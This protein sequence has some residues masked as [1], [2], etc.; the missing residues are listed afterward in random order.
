MKEPFQACMLCVWRGKGT[1][2]F[3]SGKGALWGNSSILR[4]P[5][6]QRGIEAVTF[7]ATIKYRACPFIQTQRL[8]SQN[9]CVYEKNNQVMEMNISVLNKVF[10]VWFSG[11]VDAILPG[12]THPRHVHESTGP[13]PGWLLPAWSLPA[14]PVSAGAVAGIYSPLSI[15]YRSTWYC[16]KVIT[17]SIERL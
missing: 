3:S 5:N 13:I 2:A 8:N 17:Y 14:R 6:N 10:V 12:P 15:N 1:K 16:S 11:W 9:L 4:A 7:V